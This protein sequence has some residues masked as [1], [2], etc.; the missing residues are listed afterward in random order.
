MIEEVLA[1][2]VDRSI[3]NSRDHQPP[4]DQAISI[5]PRTCPDLITSY[6]DTIC[7]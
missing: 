4:A 5:C 6:F 3:A 7:T 2:H 1:F